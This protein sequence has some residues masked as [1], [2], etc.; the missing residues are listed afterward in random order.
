MIKALI[1]LL[2]KTTYRSKEVD[3]LRGINKLPENWSEFKNY[4]KLRTNG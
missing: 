1:F 2:E 3:I 4:I